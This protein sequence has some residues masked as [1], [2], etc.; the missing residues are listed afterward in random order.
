MVDVPTIRHSSTIDSRA[1]QTD[2]TC[3]TAR[4]SKLR[5]LAM[6]LDGNRRWAR[7]RGLDPSHGYTLGGQRALEL[8]AWAQDLPGLEFVTLWPLSTENLQR[9]RGELRHLLHTIAT[10]TERI[11]AT[12]T[13]RIRIIGRPE[14]LPQSVG[15]C[16]QDAVDGTRHVTRRTVNLAVAY[17]GRDEI[18][19]AVTK[20]VAARLSAAGSPTAAE[21]DLSDI[22]NY[23]DTAGQ[24]DPDLVIRT[25]GEQ[26]L[27]GFMP[28]Q[29]AYAEYFFC[30]APW[31][32]FSRA[33]F[34]EA[35][36][37]YHARSRSFGH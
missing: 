19:R 29:A 3:T 25:A 21:R 2:G 33:S 13:W 26:R 20:L 24:P 30:S 17:G 15:R 1:A 27:S 32:D 35:V 4:P 8:L 22:S 9:D 36:A 11:A 23:L 10:T 5:H 28:W 12:G 31:P 6:I 34:D 18:V 7:A 16:L 37:H 14:R